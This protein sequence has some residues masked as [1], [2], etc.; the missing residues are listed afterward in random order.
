MQPNTMRPY[1]R[2]RKYRGKYP[3]CIEAVWGETREVE[4][5]HA[6]RNYYARTH[7]GKVYKVLV[8]DGKLPE[9]NSEITS[10]NYTR[11]KAPAYMFLHNSKVR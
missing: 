6:H 2:R 4:P 1:I 8:I 11:V 5:G 7:N 3:N 9:I 10:W